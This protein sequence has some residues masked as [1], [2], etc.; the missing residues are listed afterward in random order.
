[1]PQQLIKVR[2]TKIELIK[3]RR[4]LSLASR[5]QKIVKDRLS[6][7]VMEFLQIAKET[8]EAK[9]KLLDEFSE[10]YRA[11]SI[12]AGY[13]GYIALEKELLA[14]ERDLEIVTGSRNIAGARIPSFELKRD[15]R[16]TKGYNI[17]DTSS[18]LDQIAQL[19]EKCLEA[20]IVL[21]ELQSSL[22]LLG[23]EIN[24]TKRIVNAL[25]YL[26]IPSLQATIKFLYM[27]FEEKDREEK[28]RLKRVKVLLEQG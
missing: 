9:R 6:I 17:I 16:A 18:W 12:A 14:T 22:E 26:T 8:V 2:P 20:I 23:R 3:L 5:I 10:A 1:M 28:S 19:S 27:K 21:A 11:L 15:E 25:E 7:L 24:R 13:H 4:R